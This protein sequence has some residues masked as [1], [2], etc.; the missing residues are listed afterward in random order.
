M[1]K[2]ASSGKIRTRSARHVSKPVIAENGPA[3]LVTFSYQD[4]AYQIDLDK[5]KVYRRFIE[6]EKSRQFSI[7]HAYRSI[8]TS[9]SL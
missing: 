9:P 7:L 1:P 5:S 4:V 2:T 6:V 8:R 3:G